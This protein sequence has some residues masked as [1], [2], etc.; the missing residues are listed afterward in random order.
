MGSPLA[1][2]HIVIIFLYCNSVYFGNKYCVCLFG[3]NSNDTEYDNMEHL[4]SQVA[5]KPEVNQAGHPNTQFLD[6]DRS[7]IVNTFCC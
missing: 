4:K 1:A 6:Y 5:R 3:S 7:T 2:C